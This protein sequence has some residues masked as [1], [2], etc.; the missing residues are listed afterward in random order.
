[1]KIT[2][3][4]LSLI[5]CAVLAQDAADYTA[6][7]F[8]GRGDGD[9]R[10]IINQMFTTNP[11]QIFQLAYGMKRL[12]LWDLIRAYMPPSVSEIVLYGSYSFFLKTGPLA[13][14]QNGEYSTA[15]SSP[16]PLTGFYLSAHR[17][18]DGDKRDS[19]TST[20]V[21]WHTAGFAGKRWKLT[22]VA[23]TFAGTAFFISLACDELKYDGID[24]TGWLLAAQRYTTFDKA[25]PNFSHAFIA[26]PPISSNVWV[27]TPVDR[28]DSY[29]ITLAFDENQ[30]DGISQTRWALDYNPVNVLADRRPNDPLTNDDSYYAT[31]NNKASA[32]TFRSVKIQFAG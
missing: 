2:I 18:Y 10:T 17:Y 28:G 11:V 3:A 32:T 26:A 21:H 13:T 7:R 16:D 23:S 4:V 20:Y 9:R 27:L 29:V 15:G 31:Y 6:Q 12:K 14:V 8:L 19:R 30:L 24:Q 25:D 1:M 5:F 22:P